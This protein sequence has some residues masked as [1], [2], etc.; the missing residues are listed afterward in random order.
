VQEKS[1]QD[2]S[3]T[4]EDDDSKADADFCS[5]SDSPDSDEMTLD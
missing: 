2:F 5:L 4:S 3:S 1:D